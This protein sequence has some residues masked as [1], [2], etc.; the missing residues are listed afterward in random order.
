VAYGLRLARSSR[1]SGWYAVNDTIGQLKKAGFA[2]C[3]IGQTF[4]QGADPREVEAAMELAAL[5]VI[6]MQQA[7]KGD[8]NGKNSNG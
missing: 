1:Q 8:Q 6:F 7:K 4:L 5:N 2:V 3:I